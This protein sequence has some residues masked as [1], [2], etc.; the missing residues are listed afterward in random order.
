MKDSCLSDDD[1][2]NIIHSLTISFA[3]PALLV[4]QSGI[5]EQS[6]IFSPLFNP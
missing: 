5:F 6:Y 3:P 1:I 2:D 4:S